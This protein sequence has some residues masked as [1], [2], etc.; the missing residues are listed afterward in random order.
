MNG[1]SVTAESFDPAGAGTFALATSL[2]NGRTLHTATRL[3]SD[4]VLIAGGTSATAGSAELY[5]ATGT[6]PVLAGNMGAVRSMQTTTPIFSGL[7]LVLGGNSTAS[8]EL[9]DPE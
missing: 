5:S 3:S 8:A 2:T 9:F 6:A 4:R 1:G 7:L